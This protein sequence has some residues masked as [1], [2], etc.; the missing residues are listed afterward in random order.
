MGRAIG[1]GVLFSAAIYAVVIVALYVLFRY[2]HLAIEW[3]ALFLAT[4][5][6][7]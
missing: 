1:Y 7:W 4:V 5:L 3:F 2:G 6:P